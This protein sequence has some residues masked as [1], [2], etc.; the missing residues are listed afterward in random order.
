MTTAMLVAVPSDALSCSVRGAPQ[1]SGAPHASWHARAL[2]HQH[3]SGQL[4]RESLQERVVKHAVGAK[5]LL[6]SAGRPR[7]Q[8][9]C[10]CQNS[11]EEKKGKG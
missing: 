5:K 3:F 11:T 9:S 6:G 8:A 10:K 7:R 2:A 1:P 4:E